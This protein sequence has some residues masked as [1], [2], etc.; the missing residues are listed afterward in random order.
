MRGTTSWLVAQL[1]SAIPDFLLIYK[2]GA[3]DGLTVSA[4]R[5]IDGKTLFAR[6]K[7]GTRKA[8]LSIIKPNLKLKGAKLCPA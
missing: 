3:D 4:F 7:G 8:E 2:F 6:S 5:P 1:S